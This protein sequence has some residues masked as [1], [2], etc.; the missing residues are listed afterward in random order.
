LSFCNASAQVWRTHTEELS[1]Q[2]ILSTSV[3]VTYGGEA[4][5]R[6]EGRLQA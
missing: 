4:A 6:G 5:V 2:D 1:V 3:S